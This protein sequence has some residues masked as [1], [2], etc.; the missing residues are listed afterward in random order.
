MTTPSALQDL[1]VELAAREL[2]H[3]LGQFIAGVAITAML[4]GAVW[5]GMRKRRQELPVPRPEEQPHPPDHQTHIE[6]SGSHAETEFP[7]D[8]RRL[9]PYELR[10]HGNEVP[11]ETHPDH[12]DS[13]GNKQQ[14]A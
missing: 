7:H 5:L 3:G 1:A 8:G 12:P 10:G 11:H 9:M 14:S 6:E 4:I 13:P 2:L